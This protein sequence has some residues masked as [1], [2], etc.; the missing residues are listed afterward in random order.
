MNN[1]KNQKG[2]LL[3]ELVIVIGII[4]GVLGAILGLSTFS[5]LASSTVQQ[6][7]EA[8]ALAEEMLEAVRNYR[9]GTGWSD[10]TPGFE[11]LGV[12]STGPYYLEKSSDTPPRWQM[13]SGTETVGIFTREILFE[14]LRRDASDNLVEYPNGTPDSDSIEVN[15]IV[16]WQ[17]RGN[18]H[19]IRIVEYL[20]NWQ[21][22]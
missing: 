3:V 13:S 1:K 4:V 19:E 16:S 10:P 9:D 8:V 14:R 15:V 5:L 17:E 11:G 20:T 6:T 18:T 21:Q 22:L 7:A 12:L 2:S